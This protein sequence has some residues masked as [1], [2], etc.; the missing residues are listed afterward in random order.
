[1][2]G[3]TNA[4]QADFLRFVTSC[5][6]PPILGFRH[7]QPPLTIQMVQSDDR[8][9]T[10]ATCINLLKL[11]AYGSRDVL[12]DKLLYAIKSHSGFDLS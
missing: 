1:M 3:M 2:D 12:R 4:E 10:A 8:L 6:R 9:P 11:P 5:P 7:L